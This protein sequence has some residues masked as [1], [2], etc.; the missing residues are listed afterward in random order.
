MTTT[1]SEPDARTYLVADLFCGAGGS[2]TG[3]L[4]AIT[5]LGGTME[6]VA[7]NHWHTA[8]ET[9]QLN[10]PTARHFI[11]DLETA[12]PE[13]I[14]PEGK[15]D[16]LMA[17]PEC[18]YH[19]RARGGKP[20]GEQGRMNPWTVHRWI[21]ALDVR[22]ILVE[23]VPE[24]TDWGPLDTH[25]KRDPKRRGLYFEEWVR[26]LWG[27]GY[28]AE[29]RLLNAA[30]YGEAT[31]RRRFF[32][33]ARN[34][35]KPIRWPEPTHSKH[36]GDTLH[37][38]VPRWRGAQEIIDWSNPGRS[39]LD[40]PKYRKKPLALKTRQRIAQGLQ[41]YSSPPLAPLYVRLLDLPDYPDESQLDATQP[42][43]TQSEETQD[44][45]FIINRHGENGSA[46]CHSVHDP[47]P[48]ATCRGSGYLVTHQAEPFTCA[49]RN[50]NAPKGITEPVATLTT[51]SPGGGIFLANPVL[52]E[53]YSQSVA[54]SVEHPLP[55]VTTHDRHGLCQ[56]TLVQVNHADDKPDADRSH[57]ITAP[58]PTQTTKR[59]VALAEPTAVPVAPEA[60]Y[61]DVDPRRIV[62]IDGEPHLLDIRFRML[63][64]SELAKAMGF[65]GDTNYVF[66]GTQTEITKQIG[67]AVPVRLAAALVTSSLQE[68]A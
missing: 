11:A 48:T 23:N 57:S 39:L 12:D 50:H 67:N 61:P 16:L 30:D 3:A 33:L 1:S 14:V 66:T 21:T 55:T 59:S 18:R 4:Q 62:I 2:S 65:D 28:Q 52:V 5:A 60:G 68:T 27:L 42:Q 6:L 46:R 26:S 58:L 31:S 32:L 22:C 13:T 41:R 20:I 43:E 19:S 29:W 56:P 7:V 24:F 63:N 64:N 9:H 54:A 44:A 25:G 38:P 45:P 8:I 17:S 34:D 51:T 53:Y 49:N 35:G 40:D 36:G 15:L 10:H 37:G 47:A